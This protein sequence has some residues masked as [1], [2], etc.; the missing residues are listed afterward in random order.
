M[1]NAILY[2]C[3]IGIKS[4]LKLL[5]SSPQIVYLQINVINLIDTEIWYRDIGECATLWGG[6]TRIYT[7]T[8][9]SLLAHYWIYAE[10]YSFNFCQ[11]DIVTCLCKK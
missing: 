5:N 1:N 8:K 11:F 7:E 9:L 6:K 4:F 10:R 3:T 2:I